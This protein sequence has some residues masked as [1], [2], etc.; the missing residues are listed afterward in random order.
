MV[1]P[2]FAC[3]GVKA[4]SQWNVPAVNEPLGCLQCLSVQV[5][6]VSTVHVA[7]SKYGGFK[8]N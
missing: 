6:S 5:N 3:R 1:N 4:T 2:D 7:F 8:K